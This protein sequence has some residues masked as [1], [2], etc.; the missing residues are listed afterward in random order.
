MRT[1]AATIEFTSGDLR[2]AWP[3]L[4]EP[5]ASER[6]GRRAELIRGVLAEGHQRFQVRAHGPHN[7]VVL[8]GRSWPTNHV[9]VEVAKHEGHNTVT[10]AQLEAIAA[11]KRFEIDLA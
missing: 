2:H 5:A 8:N 10:A 6:F 9:T 11:D 1:A 7:F 4:S 3:D